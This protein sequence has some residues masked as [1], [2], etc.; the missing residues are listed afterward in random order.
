MLLKNADIEQVLI[1]DLNSYKQQHLQYFGD[2][3]AHLNKIF[4]GSSENED[5]FRNL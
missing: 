3:K 1:D 5:F 4:N 2:C